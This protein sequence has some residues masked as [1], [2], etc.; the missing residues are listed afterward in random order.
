MNYRREV[1]GLRAL[2]I[3]PVILFHAGFQTFSGG[4]VGVDIFFV[5]SGY[6]ITSII[7][8]EKQADTFTF[9]NFYE[10]RARRI[11]P[12]LFTVMFVCLP[13]AWFWL[14]PSDL[15][16]FS[17]SL[18][19]V[20]GFASNI[21]FWKTSSYFATSAEL[22]PLLHTWSLAVEEQYYLF[23]PVFLIS[24]WRFGKYWILTI[25]ALA[26]VI[27]L[28][29]AQ[30]GS[31][32]MQSATFYLLSTR[33]W[34][35]LI[36]AFLAFYFSNKVKS[37]FNKVSN[38]VGSIIGL[39]L[40]AYAIFMFDKYT[41]FPGLYALIPTI[42]TA[43]IILCATQQ[44]YVGRLLGN[45]LLVGIGL[46]SYS[47][48]LWHQPL[49]AFTKHIS[50]DEPSKFL[51]GVLAIVAM[52]LGYLSWKY[53]EKPFR[54]KKRI[55]RKEIFVFAVIGSVF[56]ISIGLIGHFNKGFENRFSKEQLAIIALEKYN[57]K[58]VYKFRSCFLD[59]NQDYSAFA[60]DCI[61]KNGSEILIW[62]D[63]HAAALAYGLQQQLGN[64]IQ[65]TASGCPPIKDG[66][67][68]RQAKCKAI[69]DFVLK[70][71]NRLKPK[72]IFLH[73]NWSSDEYK[74]QDPLGNIHKTIQYIKSFSP[75]SLIYI[76]GPV[77]HWYPSL[78]KFAINK[79][80]KLDGEHFLQNS[81]INDLAKIDYLLSNV[82]K[83]E[84]VS[85]LSALN[86]LC[87]NK[88]CLAST[89]YKNKPALTAWDYGHLTEAGSVSLAQKIFN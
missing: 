76:I 30:W 11:L 39:I 28:T 6:L 68:S 29:A 74:N 50:I 34:E 24:I 81:T 71:I 3:L 21:L 13:F 60:K 1:D 40:V 46:I 23:F 73:A 26:T 37:Q 83:Q 44:T 16:N 47:A 49:F 33:G 87:R 84:E 41:P 69:N 72:Q 35:L 56:F 62:G 31:V 67:F 48:Y 63:S 80:D 54:D 52:V 59:A 82:A 51:M 5:I 22:K 17:Q 12:A 18:V 85:F 53:V 10:R 36:G 58:N 61:P 32:A 20:S 14:F 65:Y 42:G 75:S 89:I 19:A 9:M 25:F 2:A 64:I 78:P 70:E 79:L 7:L 8:T 45:N 55:N 4:F 15:K 27:S 38:E 66:I 86:V 43:L 88:D 77:P 57:Y